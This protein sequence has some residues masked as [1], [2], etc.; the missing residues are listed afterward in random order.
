VQQIAIYFPSD[1]VVQE[2]MRIVRETQERMAAEG[3][4]PPEPTWWQK[5]LAPEQMQ[6]QQQQLPER[7]STDFDDE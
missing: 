7:F 2:Q 6:Q 5:M 3:V 1:A 4:A